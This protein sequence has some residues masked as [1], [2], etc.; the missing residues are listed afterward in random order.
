MVN[1]KKAEMAAL[2]ARCYLESEECSDGAAINR[3]IEAL[4]SDLEYEVQYEAADHA[5]SRPRPKIP[6]VFPARLMP[7]G[8]PS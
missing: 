5:C 7:T 2:V 8:T 4:L 3:A 6:I 1:V